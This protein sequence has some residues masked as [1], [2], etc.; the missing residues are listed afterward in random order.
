M[1]GPRTL[2]YGSPKN[3]AAG[4]GQAH[5]GDDHGHHELLVRRLD[6][7]HVREVGQRIRRGTVEGDAGAHEDLVATAQLRT[8]QLTFEL[9]AIAANVDDRRVEARSEAPVLDRLPRDRRVLLD[10]RLHPEQYWRQLCYTAC[11]ECVAGSVV[12]CPLLVVHCYLLVVHC[13]LLRHES[14]QPGGC[15]T[16]LQMQLAKTY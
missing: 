12:H 10:R 11:V 7:A 14:V 15:A 2:A 8:T 5:L 6:K 16:L 1:G 9:T 13:Y 4:E 3:P